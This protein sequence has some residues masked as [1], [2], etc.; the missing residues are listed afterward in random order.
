MA[1][2]ELPQ[3]DLAMLRAMIRTSTVTTTIGT[4]TVATS[5][6]IIGGR[7]VMPKTETGSID[8]V[9]CSA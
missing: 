4:M 7:N 8:V 6:A 5:P 2:S 1:L 9:S 3:G